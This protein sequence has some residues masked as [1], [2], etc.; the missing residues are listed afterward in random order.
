[1]AVI[2]AFNP[3]GWDWQDRYSINMALEVKGGQR[4]IYCTGQASVDEHSQPMYAGDFL[5]QV[6]KS[7]DNLEAVL[8][9]AGLS[10]ANVVRLNQYTTDLA[11]WY[12]AVPA[13]RARLDAA[14]CKPTG[15]LLVVAGLFH[16]DLMFEM[17]ATAVA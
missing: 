5:K 10:L 17:E 14:G 7:F 15:T 16:P 2:S 12:K 8:K 6:N 9:S 4:V 3:E 13:Y 11:E 1:M